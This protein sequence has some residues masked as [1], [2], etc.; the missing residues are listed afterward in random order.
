MFN[1]FLFFILVIYLFF[2]TYSYLHSK[3]L[4]HLKLY[5][6][7]FIVTISPSNFPTHD[8]G[9][10]FK[11]KLW[12]TG[13]IQLDLAYTI[14]FSEFLLLYLCFLLL[15]FFVNA[16][17]F[18]KAVLGQLLFA[19]ACCY[20]FFRSYLFEAAKQFVR[21]HDTSPSPTHAA[22]H[23]H[24]F[25]ECIAKLAAIHQKSVSAFF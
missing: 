3:S 9:W 25:N 19:V 24:C 20:C 5:I 2:I 21:Q 12:A 18:V 22:M 6:H 23:L 16:L 14:R 8:F 10:I 7:T 4:I 11:E 13:S 17:Q 1:L 15:L